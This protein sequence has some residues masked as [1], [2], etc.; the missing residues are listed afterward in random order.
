LH[1]MKLAI[2]QQFANPM[3]TTPLQ[4]FTNAALG[5]TKSELLAAMENVSP[6]YRVARTVYQQASP[7]VNQAEILN[8]IQST[9]SGPAGKENALP[10]LRSLREEGVPFLKKADQQKRFSTLGEALTDE[11]MAAVG[12][13]ESE[14]ERDIRMGA[15]AKAGRASLDKALTSQEGMI[16]Q[17]FDKWNA[18]SRLKSGIS[19]GEKV[20]GA[21]INE[22]AE[23]IVMEAM[24]DGK[25]LNDIM[26][27]LPADQRSPVMNALARGGFIPRASQVA[28]AAIA[29]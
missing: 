6:L 14:L 9:L 2:D 11:Q 20:T 22:K 27:L 5:S 16:K 15:Q 8:K 13:V 17:A 18:L 10:F 4:N 1:A 24:R 29:E 12:K 21:I 23:K 26:R 28:P 25:S 3:A 19:A 7:E